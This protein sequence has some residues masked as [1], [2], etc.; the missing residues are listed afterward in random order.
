MP[1]RGN[2]MR[3]FVPLLLLLLL[4]PAVAFGGDGGTDLG[5]ACPREAAAIGAVLEKAR[6]EGLPSGRLERRVNEGLLRRVPC[7]KLLAALEREYRLLTESRT[8]LSSV[9][10]AGEDSLAL[11]TDLRLAGLEQASVIRLIAVFARQRD[12]AAAGQAGFFLLSMKELEWGEDRVLPLAVL[13]AARQTEGGYREGLR[14]ALLYGASLHIPRERVVASV[15][16]SVR[17][18]QSLRRI[19][20]ALADLRLVR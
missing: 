17:Q 12:L 8:L 10:A 14:Q 16:E 1:E 18:G 13:L 6:R 19:R 3:S 7:E 2:A 5:L 20:Q 4:S 11:F 15:A 9:F